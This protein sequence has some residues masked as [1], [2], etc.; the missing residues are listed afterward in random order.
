MVTKI[1]QEWLY[2]DKIEIK[3]RPITKD[4]KRT[5]YHDKRFNSLGPYNNFK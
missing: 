3:S 5:L 4:K 2:L 1:E